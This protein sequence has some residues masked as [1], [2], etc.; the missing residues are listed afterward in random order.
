MPLLLNNRNNTTNPGLIDAKSQ[1]TEENL[2]SAFSDPTSGLLMY[3]QYSGSNMKSGAELTHL[4]D[5]AGDLCFDPK[6]ARHFNHDREKKH[7][8]KYLK[9]HSNLFH[10]EHGWHR[11]SLKIWL[12]KEAFC[13]R[14][15]MMKPSIQ[16]REKVSIPC[17]NT[18]PTAR[19]CRDDRYW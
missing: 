9:D 16:S 4:K 13:W 12:P 17:R 6:C 5:C 18:D 3:W 10:A 7:I 15:H 2:F 1:I 14:R 8:E 11:S 19:V